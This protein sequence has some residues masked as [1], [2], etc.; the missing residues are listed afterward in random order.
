M[1]YVDNPN[2]PTFF[3]LIDTNERLAWYDINKN[4]KEGISLDANWL[5]YQWTY[6]RT[7]QQRP[8]PKRWSLLLWE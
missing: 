1:S 8:D 4:F 6:E 3:D 2:Q 7:C 5:Y